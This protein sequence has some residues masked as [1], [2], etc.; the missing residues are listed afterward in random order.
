MTQPLVSR[1]SNLSN[2]VSGRRSPRQAGPGLYWK[3]MSS[4]QIGT[5]GP[6]QPNAW[7]PENRQS[8]N[9]ARPVE[10][11]TRSSAS[12]LLKAS[13]PTNTQMHTLVVT[14]RASVPSQTQ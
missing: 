3:K 5:L 7:E 12:V 13:V 11:Q 8:G 14:D 9:P 6:K 1:P 10:T 2:I 4:I